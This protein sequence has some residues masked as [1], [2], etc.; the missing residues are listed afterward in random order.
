[1]PPP[2]KPRAVLKKPQSLLL[3]PG[4]V[5]AYPADSRGN[6]VNPYFP[7]AYIDETF[8]HTCWGSM[9]VSAAG[10]EFEFLAW[11]RLT[12]SGVYTADCP[13]LALASVDIDPT[14]GGVGP[15]TATHLRRLRLDLLGRIDGFESVWTDRASVVA[16]VANDI[17]VCNALMEFAEP[18]TFP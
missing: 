12:K 7:D 15:L 13:D 17:S 11:Y 5:Y 3:E 2:N 18:G 14:G 1:V 8:Q 16:S 9:L 10:H 6:S 4:Q